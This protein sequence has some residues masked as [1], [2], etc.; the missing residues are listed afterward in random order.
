VG[1]WGLN[2]FWEKSQREYN[3]LGFIAFLLTNFTQIF[4]GGSYV[5]L[6]TP[7]TPL[8]AS[9]VGLVEAE[10]SVMLPATIVHE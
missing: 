4:L 3:I 8:F 2:I 1:V 10:L 9:V 5:I 6:L 7:F